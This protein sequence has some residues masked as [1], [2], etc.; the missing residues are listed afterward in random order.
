MCQQ[1]VFPN[2]LKIAE[3]IP[4]AYIKKCDINKSTNYRLIA[5]LSQYNI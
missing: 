4:I 1:S 5:L 3:I 2:C